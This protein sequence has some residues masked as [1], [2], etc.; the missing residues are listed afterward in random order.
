[1]LA[2]QAQQAL[3]PGPNSSIYCLCYNT[4]NKFHEVFGPLYLHIQNAD[5]NTQLTIFLW[6]LN[7][8]VWKNIKYCLFPIG[9]LN[10]K[11]RQIL[12]L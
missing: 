1:M 2:Q 8:E 5:H 10:L 12:L 9:L 3:G 4:L 11:D 7:E 6:G